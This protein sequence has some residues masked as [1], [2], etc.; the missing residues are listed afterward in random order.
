MG[1]SIEGIGGAIGSVGA[2][3]SVAPAISMPSI[4]PSVSIGM[5]GAASASG[6][7]FSA[8]PAFEAA[9]SLSSFGNPIAEGPV[10]SL[11][12]FV[13]LAGPLAAPD[14]GGEAR[15]LGDLSSSVPINTFGVE[16]PVKNFSWEGFEPMYINSI[17]PDTAGVNEPAEIFNIT[18]MLVAS[19]PELTLD[20]APKEVQ[21]LIAEAIAEE[22]VIQEAPIWSPKIIKEATYWYTDVEEPVVKQAEIIMPNAELIAAPTI[23]EHPQ[24]LRVVAPTEYETEVE[25]ALG[26]RVSSQSETQGK[27][28]VQPAVSLQPQVQEIEEI[29][30]E[31]QKLTD[32]GKDQIAVTSSEEQSQVKVKLVEAVEISEKRKN[33]IKAAVRSAKP[34]EAIVLPAE[35]WKSNSPIVGEGEDRT[36]DLTAQAVRSVLEKYSDPKEAEGALV[37]TVD[38]N[39]PVKEG[40][41]SR[42]ATYEEVR[43]VIRGE[44]LKKLGTSKPAEMVVKRVVKKRFEVIK[45]GEVVKVVENTV[46]T[47]PE[48]TLEQ[49]NPTLAGVFQKAA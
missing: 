48:N 3:V 20:Y 37:K 25:N 42:Q 7:N 2:G 47:T 22:V 33:A 14:W 4:G 41:G 45:N 19:E 32:E 31:E 8:M 5:E 49:L 36:I 12:G 43:K 15:A 9:P 16:G 23:V 38:E 39:I 44:D 6:F 28:F 27:V 24:P 13:N 21:P 11:E 40:E 34:G 10:S 30:E 46:T 35:F 18:P 1:L 26:A 29:V 17:L